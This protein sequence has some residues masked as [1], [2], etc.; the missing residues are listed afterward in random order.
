RAVVGAAEGI[1]GLVALL[2]DVGL[3]E[4]EHPG[5]AAADLLLEQQ[6]G[7]GAADG[8]VL[9]PV[10]ASPEARQW[11]AV[12]C[13]GAE[14]PGGLGGGQASA[15]TDDGGPETDEHGSGGLGEACGAQEGLALGESVGEE[16]GGTPSAA[17]DTGGT[18]S[19]YRA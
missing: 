12:A 8:P 7:D 19:L 17:E 3:V 16:H 10:T 5:A 13:L 2:A 9:G 14:G 15:V 11:G 4:E 6:A 1:R 18:P